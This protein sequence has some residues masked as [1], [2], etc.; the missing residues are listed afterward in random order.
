MSPQSNLFDV[1]SNQLQHPSGHEIIEILEQREDVRIER[2]ISTGQSSP[3]GFWY[4]QDETEWVT[5]IAGEGHLRIEGNSEL[6][7]MKPGDWVTIPAHQK[8]RVEWTHPDQPTIWLAVFM[9]V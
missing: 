1:T 9:R 5:V 3:E 2:I 6:I 7:R 4:D 8:H